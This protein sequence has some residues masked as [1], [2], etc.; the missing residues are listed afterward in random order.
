MLFPKYPSIRLDICSGY[1]CSYHIR[2]SELL[3]RTYLDHIDHIIARVRE[4]PLLFASCSP[5]RPYTAQSAS[6]LRL[7]LDELIS[8]ERDPSSPIEQGSRGRCAARHAPLTADSPHSLLSSCQRR[9][10]LGLAC[11]QSGH[12]AAGG[13]KFVKQN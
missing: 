12:S 9:P 6:F 2:S 1:I 7:I 13:I 10:W 4:C 8:S 5:L 11:A 3:L